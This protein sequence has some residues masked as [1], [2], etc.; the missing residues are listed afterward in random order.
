MFEMERPR[1]WRDSKLVKVLGVGI[2][3]LLLLIPLGMVRSLVLERQQRQAGV[4]AEIAR[5]WGA[6][7]TLTGPVLSIPYD[8][9]CSVQE[10]EKDGKVVFV[11]RPCEKQAHF[12]PETLSVDGPVSPERR[13]RG[14]FNVVVYRTELRIQG[15]FLVPSFEDLMRDS[16]A[17]VGP[18]DAIHWS[19]ASLGIGIPDLRGIRGRVELDWQ[20]KRV[21][22]S[23]GVVDSNLWTAG[24][25]APLRLDDPAKKPAAGKRIPFSLSV[26][27]GGSGGLRL[28]PFGRQTRLALRS[29]WP[30]PSF[31]GAFLPESRTVKKDGFQ[32]AWNVSYYGRSFPQQW[33][34]EETPSLMEAIAGSS[35]G[36]D[37]VQPVDIYQQ[38]ERSVKYGALFLVLTFVTFFL[39]EL[40]QPIRVHPVQY[41][42][43][44]SALCLFYV[45]LLSLAEQV[46]F[47]WA[48]L[49]A[50]G[51]TV[52][53]LGAYA[54]AVLHGKG[55]AGV[56][57]GV[58]GL[59]YAYLYVLLQAEDY[60]LLLGSVGL[61][62][63]L[64]LV[65]LIT[66]R[67]D[68]Y[69]STAEPAEPATGG[70]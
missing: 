22:F 37:F 47:G 67:V 64:A 30:S 16:G 46:A 27:L 52:L 19:R 1:R 12:L 62:L 69:G 55:R 18:V 43:V 10:T 66:R 2:L 28:M 49:I 35:F 26:S 65:M 59:L 20:G 23:P 31:V 45:L 25:R 36:V 32:A 3:V 5:I 40:F 4:Q 44:G 56:F 29:T 7:Q 9:V 8:S 61:F 15:D 53:L 51:A 48:Y 11:M 14:I 13:A 39:F 50:G 42:M 24:L 60:A 17:K 70:A 41:L 57:A 6:A 21:P 33:A 63:I 58:L 54:A 68:W 38:T 34:W